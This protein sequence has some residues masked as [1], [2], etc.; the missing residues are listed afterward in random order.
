VGRSFP[1]SI[2]CLSF[3]LY[4][5]SLFPFSHSFSIFRRQLYLGRLRDLEIFGVLISSSL[6]LFFSLLGDRNDTQGVVQSSHQTFACTQSKASRASTW[7]S[8]PVGDQMLPLHLTCGWSA[9]S[10]SHNIIVQFVCLFCL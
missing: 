9:A 2:L 7:Q 8:D 5:S 10:L 6:S 1:I 3:F 4:S